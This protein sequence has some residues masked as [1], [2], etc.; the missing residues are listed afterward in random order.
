MT[1]SYDV[2]FSEDLEEVLF[3]VFDFGVDAG[4]DELAV[5]DEVVL[6]DVV[7]VEE[8]VDLLPREVEFYFLLVAAEDW[9]NSC[10]FWR[11]LLAR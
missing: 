11:T 10:Y 5:V 4:G 8:Q 2:D 6:V 1:E 3:E 9:V 7:G